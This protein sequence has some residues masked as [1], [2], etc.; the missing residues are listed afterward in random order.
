MHK[1]IATPIELPVIESLSPQNQ[2]EGV[3]LPK[4]HELEDLNIPTTKYPVEERIGGSIVRSTVEVPDKLLDPHPVVY[5]HGYFGFK[6]AYSELR[7]ATARNGKIAV[8]YHPPRSQNMLTAFHS[9]HIISPQKLLIQAV[10]GA[11]RG[12]ERLLEDIGTEHDKF[13][14]SGHSMGGR[15][16]TEAAHRNDGLVRSVILNEAAGLEEHDL[17]MMIS[18]LP[19][20]FKKELIPAIIKKEF[21]HNR[22]GDI[23]KQ[24]AHYMLR[25][26]YKTLLEGIIVADCDIRDRVSDLGNLGI[27]TAILVGQS[28][29]L[30]S[31][32][33]TAEKSMG[34]SDIFAHYDAKEANH[35]WAQTHPLETALTHKQ[36]LSALHP[37]ASNLRLV[38]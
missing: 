4:A 22:T 1:S 20:F 2:F 37:I 10:I 36:I 38:A 6:A 15:S 3:F 29:T 30:I 17:A 32:E 31:A 24:S 9:T 8:T 25:N 11:M 26:P 19:K 13:D 14:L 23:I 27:K 18:R 16:A 28:D 35:I 7:H 12:T 34:I 21:A 33:R 5:A